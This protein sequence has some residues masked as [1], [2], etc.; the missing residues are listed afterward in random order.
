MLSFS[1]SLTWHPF[2]QNKMENL[3]WWLLQL[4]VFSL[5]LQLFE[6][7]TILCSLE[8]IIFIWYI[9]WAECTCSIWYSRHLY[10]LWINPSQVSEGGGCSW[11]IANP[12]A[13]PRELRR[14]TFNT[15][16]ATLNCGAGLFLL[17]QCSAVIT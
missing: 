8:C 14:G 2:I 3:K 7:K 12:W 5:L 16:S 17:L 13:I 10:H 9:N 15:C 6:M 11:S 1:N 4:T